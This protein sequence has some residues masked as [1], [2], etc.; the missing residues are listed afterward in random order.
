[1]KITEVA[2]TG[3]IEKKNYFFMHGTEDVVV[4]AVD[5]RDAEAAF[6]SFS[7]SLSFLT[8]AEWYTSGRIPFVGSNR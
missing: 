4:D 5:S 1:M 3:K 6:R 8:A 7:S 2:Y